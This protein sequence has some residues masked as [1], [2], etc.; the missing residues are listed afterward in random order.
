MRPKPRGISLDHPRLAP[1]CI[2]G[3][4]TGDR[5]SGLAQSSDRSDNHPRDLFDVKLMLDDIGLS[6]EI[7]LGMFA[8]LVSHG[9]PIAELL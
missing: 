2:S 4:K 6:D 3:I 5:S 8:A 7:R 1:P 9:R